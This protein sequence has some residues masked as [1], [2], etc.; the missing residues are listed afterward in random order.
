MNYPQQPG[1]PPYG[2]GA[3]PPP[4]GQAPRSGNGRTLLWLSAGLVVV[5]L[6]IGAVALLVLRDDDS[7]DSDADAAGSARADSC[8]VYSDAMLNV[9]TWAAADSDPDQFQELY[10]ALAEDITDDEIRDLVAKEAEVVVA[11]KRG[12]AEWKQSMEEALRKGEEPDTTLPDNLVG[13]N[14]GVPQAQAAVVEACAD[15]LGTDNDDAPIPEIT[16]PSLDLP[17]GM[18]ED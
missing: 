15:V 12:M 6:V 7:S 16:A 10:D 5:L 8:E 2:Q 3:Y 1:M 18:G 17:S 14:S 13:A 11:Q 4:P 9:E